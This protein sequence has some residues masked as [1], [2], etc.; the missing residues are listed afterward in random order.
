MSS[1]QTYVD[2]MLS[3]VGAKRGNK[4]HK[5]IVD[6]YNSYLPH[7]RGHKL[8]M[9]DAWCA[10]TVSAASIECG[11]ENI[12]PIECSCNKQIA[13]FRELAEWHEDENYVPNI[14][15]ICYYAWNDGKDY[16]VTDCTIPA[17]HVGVVVSVDEASGKFKVCE[18]NKGDESVCGIRLVDVNG[19]YLRGF[20]I[21]KY[22]DA[23]VELWYTVQKGDNLTKIAKKFGTTVD[24]I[25]QINHIKNRNLIYPGQRLRVK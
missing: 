1:R 14:G 20:A 15:D 2:K 25:V 4:M 19:R 8:T 23:P 9:S 24:Y 6:V 16:P 7:P 13:L 11:Y 18:G 12:I 3:Y 10:A 5:H 17:N 21:P 22:D